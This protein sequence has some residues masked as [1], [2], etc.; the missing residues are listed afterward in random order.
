MT[1]GFR[2][3]GVSRR[4]KTNHRRHTGL[5]SSASAA[6]PATG[7]GGLYQMERWQHPTRDTSPELPVASAAAGRIQT[8]SSLCCPVLC[9]W[10]SVPGSRSAASS[11][12]PSPRLASPRR[13]LGP[14]LPFR[15]NISWEPWSRSLHRSRNAI[16]SGLWSRSQIHPHLLAECFL[17]IW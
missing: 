10:I 5:V 6:V 3:P 14:H 11:A 7:D 16:L 8:P 17:R 13:R 9:S 2:L 1:P 4:A 12:S 15:A